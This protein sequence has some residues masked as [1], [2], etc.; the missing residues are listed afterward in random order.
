M[1]A[2]RL[3][4]AARRAGLGEIT[5]HDIHLVS[6][7]RGWG[8]ENLLEDVSER[9]ARRHSD[10]YIVGAANVGK[11]TLLNTLLS[12]E[13]SLTGPTCVVEQPRHLSPCCVTQKLTAHVQA[14]CN[15]GRGSCGVGVRW[16]PHVL[17]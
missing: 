14:G 1:F 11:S 4:G 10:I 6:C 7:A 8:I 5:S 13:R 15:A 2:F 17:G 16:P 12:D 9:A 3:A